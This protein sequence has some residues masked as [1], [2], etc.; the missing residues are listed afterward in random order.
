MVFQQ[1][2]KQRARYFCLLKRCVSHQH[3]SQIA[4]YSEV[5]LLAKVSTCTIFDFPVILEL[6]QLLVGL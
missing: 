2:E 1:T 3:L 6:V 4:V 5:F